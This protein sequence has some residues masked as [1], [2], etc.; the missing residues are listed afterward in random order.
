MT[1]AL[2]LPLF[3]VRGAGLEIGD[4]LKEVMAPS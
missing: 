3:V 4:V 1:I 2:G